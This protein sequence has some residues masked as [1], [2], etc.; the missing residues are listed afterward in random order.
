MMKKTL[1]CTALVLLGASIA[2]SQSSEVMSEIIDSEKA[3][4]AQIAYLPALYANKIT[5]DDSSNSLGVMPASKDSSSQTKAAFDALKSEA[6]FA[7]GDEADSVATVSKISFVY[8]KALGIKGG[9]FYTLLPSPRY[10]FKQFQS[11]GILSSKL[12]PSDFVSG[13]KA[14]SIYTSCVKKYSDFN[15]KAVSMEA[16]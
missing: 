6:F 4:C 8:M 10:A 15:M 5:E 1:L 12:E 2:F 11:D 9:L 13:A 7:E 3:T 14:L 16:D